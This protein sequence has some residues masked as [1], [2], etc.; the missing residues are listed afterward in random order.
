MQQE[1]EKSSSE[2]CRKS[3]RLSVTT[4]ELPTVGNESVGSFPQVPG[5]GPAPDL[6]SKV[7]SV[8]FGEQVCGAT[9][10]SRQCSH[11][12]FCAA[13]RPTWLARL[14]G[15]LTLRHVEAASLP[16]AGLIAWAGIKQVGCVARVV[17]HVDR[18]LV[19]G[20]GRAVGGVATQLL[21]PQFQ[22]LKEAMAMGDDHPAVS[23]QGVSRVLG[24]T[25][26]DYQIQLALP[27]LELDSAGRGGKPARLLGPSER[28][29][30]LSSPLLGTADNVGLL[31]GTLI[32]IN[33][34]VKLNCLSLPES[35]TDSWES[36]ARLA[37][38]C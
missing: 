28:L 23:S 31:A 10:P 6:S 20:A 30:S 16:Y 29:G 34:L 8:G 38:Y 2:G 13:T 3:S 5:P 9:F 14:T 1:G 32:I 11:Q 24:Y 35:N 27:P 7:V 4:I 19:V 36:S 12:N 18:V 37:S 25:E 33:S 26:S 15:S 22:Y 17:G 21:G